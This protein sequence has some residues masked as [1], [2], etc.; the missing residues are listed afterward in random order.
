MEAATAD[1]MAGPS[2]VSRLAAMAVFSG[3]AALAAAHVWI[4]V[5]RV[6]WVRPVGALFNTGLAIKEGWAAWY[7]APLFAPALT[8]ALLH[9]YFR[10]P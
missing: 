6:P 3:L 4:N 2:H 9:R 10:R 7:V 5:I 1:Q 8:L